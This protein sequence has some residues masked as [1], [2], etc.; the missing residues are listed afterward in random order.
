MYSIYFQVKFVNRTEQ[1]RTEQNRTE[2]N[3]TEQNYYKAYFIAKENLA[4]FISIV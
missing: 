2:Q 3:R 1:N 4:K